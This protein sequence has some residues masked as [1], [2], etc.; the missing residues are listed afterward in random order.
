M[1]DVISMFAATT[2]GSEDA[3]AM[4]DVPQDG[5]L[6]GIDWDWRVALDAAET[7][8]VELSFLATNQ[9]STSDVR[10][11]ISSV[12]A[13]AAVITAVGAVFGTM[14]KWL[15]SFDISISG[16]ERLFLHANATAG[17]VSSGRVGLYFDFTGSTVRRPAR[18]R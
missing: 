14:Q 3:I 12:S 17:V 7:L 9:I 6:I 13:Q 4:I 16:G 5:F 1:S 2:G 18:R 10:G 15:G 11:R 8:A